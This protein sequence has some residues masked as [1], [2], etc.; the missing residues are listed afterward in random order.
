MVY[1]MTTKTYVQTL[2]D[3]R[4]SQM[5]VACLYLF[6][7]EC[8]SES[9]PAR[10]RNFELWERRPSKPIQ[11]PHDHALSISDPSSSS[12]AQMKDFRLAQRHLERQIRSGRQ[13]AVIRQD[14]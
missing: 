6:K 11:T 13:E 2:I 8:S 10:F 7:L 5:I 14:G 1:I 3:A 12:G 4:N 9:P